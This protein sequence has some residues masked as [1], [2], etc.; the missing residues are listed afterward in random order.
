MLILIKR[1]QYHVLVCPLHHPFVMHK[2]SVSTRS[3]TSR[4]LSNAN[5]HNNN[6]HDDNDKQQQ[7]QQQLYFLAHMNYAKLKAPMNDPIM[8]ELRNAMK[9]IN[10][11]AKTTPGF[12]WSYDYDDTT[13][14]Y[15]DLRKEVKL[16]RIDP[17]IMPQLSLWNNINSIQHF[18]Y[19][20]GHFIYYK[21]R[22]EWFIPFENNNIHYSVCWWWKNKS[23]SSNEFSFSSYPTLK[24]A[25]ERC[26]YLNQHGPSLY[27]FDFASAKDYPMPTQ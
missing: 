8:N 26:D 14:E 1:Q 6:N 19:K 16:L 22:K 7:Q 23:S 25:F 5:H 18:A 15:H 17:L 9:P 27:A 2:R 12:I 21:R 3:Y 20:S 13:V 24:D 4:F 11:I 10:D